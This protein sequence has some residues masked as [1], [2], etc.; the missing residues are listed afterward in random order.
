MKVD[1]AVS[2]IEALGLKTRVI[3]PRLDPPSIAFADRLDGAKTVFWNG[4]MGVFEI[5]A[6]AV[7]TNAVARAVAEL[8][9]LPT[10]TRELARTVERGRR[11]AI[12]TWAFESGG[13]ILEGGRRAG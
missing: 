6:F 3:R 10:M 12:G 13:F 8:Y 9:E 5:D 7:G 2:T 1:E 4:P 11:S